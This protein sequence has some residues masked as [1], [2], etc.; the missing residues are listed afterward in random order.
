M[1]NREYLRQIL[2]DQKQLM[3]LEEVRFIVVPKFDE[4]SVANI[5]SNFYED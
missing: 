5:S 2:A 1:L 3:K 4:L